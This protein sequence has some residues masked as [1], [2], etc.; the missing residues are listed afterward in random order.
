MSPVRH[1]HAFACVMLRD[2][3]N[4]VEVDSHLS[5]PSDDCLKNLW[6]RP[7]EGRMKRIDQAASRRQGLKL[8]LRG[9]KKS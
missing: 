1:G 5:C 6:S 2:L 7:D 4:L 8:T 9:P 3:E